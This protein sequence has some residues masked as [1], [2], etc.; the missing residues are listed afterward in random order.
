[1]GVHKKEKSRREREGKAHDGMANV[2]VKGTN[3]YR[4]VYIYTAM[5]PLDANSLQRCEKGKSAQAPY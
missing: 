5:R 1:M 4:Y 3:F 2:K